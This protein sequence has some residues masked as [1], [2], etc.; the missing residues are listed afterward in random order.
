[1]ILLLFAAVKR[2]SRNREVK[3]MANNTI[4]ETSS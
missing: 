2:L 3:R 4:E 1:V